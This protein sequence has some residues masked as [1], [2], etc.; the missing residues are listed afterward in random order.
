MGQNLT[1]GIY[2]PDEGER[3]CYS[4][5]AA[6]W[7]LLDNSVGTIAE[8]TTALSGKAPLVH[9]HTKSDITDFP[10]YGN[11]AGTICEGND[12]RLSD[13][14]TPIA[15]THTK[16]DVTDLFNSANTWAGN[17][18]YTG[19]I[20]LNT[21]SDV[22]EQFKQKLPKDVSASNDAMARVNTVIDSAGHYVFVETIGHWASY[23]AKNITLKYK[24]D[25][26]KQGAI[27]FRLYSD[28]TGIFYPQSPFGCDLGN[29]YNKWKTLNGINPGALSLPNLDSTKYDP[30]DFSQWNVNLGWGNDYTP[31][32]DGWIHVNIKD[33]TDCSVFV[34][35]SNSNPMYATSAYGNGSQGL[36][37]RVALMMP[38]RTGVTYTFMVK[39][40][41]TSD[42][43]SVIFIPALGNV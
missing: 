36:T 37:G 14:R 12:S 19:M 18:T 6:N 3:N 29:S 34:F 11:A 16:S 30:I 1:H 38:V 5:L 13:A 4:G 23:V 2:L 15:H 17:Q 32:S 26:A 24:N 10:V 39:A 27:E 20:T 42:I 41:S 7:Q 33:S 21:S 28:G 35:A 25:S 43:Y 22:A 31:Q 40:S 9:T 8:H